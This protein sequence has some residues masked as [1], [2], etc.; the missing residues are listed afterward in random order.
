MAMA[1]IHGSKIYIIN[2]F[3]EIRD[4]CYHLNKPSFIKNKFALETAWDVSLSG[5]FI[6]TGNVLSFL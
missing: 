4:N 3:I 5:F 6:K 1:I 2:S